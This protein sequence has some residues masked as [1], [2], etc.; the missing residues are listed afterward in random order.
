[1]E[2]PW[3]RLHRYPLIVTLDKG[4]S[5][6]SAI[7][8]RRSAI[9]APM[10]ELG[11]AFVLS[12]VLI[13]ILGL[14]IRLA[15]IR[16]NRLLNDTFESGVMLGKSMADSDLFRSYSELADERNEL[17]QILEDQRTA[18]KDHEST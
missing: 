8:R 16:R 14:W 12:G 10:N 17:L 7:Q 5:A 11:I 2:P 1:M 9:L 4:E 6:S 3:S 18:T 13:V 15:V